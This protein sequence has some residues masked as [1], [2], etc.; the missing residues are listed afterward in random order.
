[1]RSNQPK[2]FILRVRGHTGAI[3]VVFGLLMM[4]SAAPAL[5]ASRPMADQAWSKNTEVKPDSPACIKLSAEIHK[6]VVG[7]NALRMS[8][9]KDLKLP[10]PSVTGLFKTWMGQP[11]T[12]EAMKRK[13]SKLDG[14]LRAARELNAATGTLGC[15]PVNI[16]QELQLEAARFPPPGSH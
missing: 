15:A 9:D 6:H 14:E 7:A 12:S 10:P 5:A 2:P 3:A 1:M 4:G 16:D 13:R 8:I 11:Y